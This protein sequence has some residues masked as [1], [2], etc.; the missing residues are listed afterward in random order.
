MAIQMLETQAIS[1]QELD[2]VNGGGAG[3]PLAWA[4]GSIPTVG[5]P[6]IADAFTGDHITKATQDA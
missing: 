5:I 1:D 6:M 4:F 3:A 2:V